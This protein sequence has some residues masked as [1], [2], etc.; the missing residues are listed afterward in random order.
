MARR[1]TLINS[2]LSAL[3]SYYM[4][5]ML[6]P[7]NLLNDIS[8]RSRSF[9]WGKS[10]GERKLHLISWDLAT[11]DKKDGGLGIKD[12]PKHNEAFIMKLCWKLI[13]FPNALWVL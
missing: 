7:K 5:T 10:E 13:N 8:K 1:T 12:L 2:V 6:L 11:T 9:L 3:P 4:Q